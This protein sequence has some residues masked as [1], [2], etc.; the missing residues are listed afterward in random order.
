MHPVHQFLE[1]KQAAGDT[2]PGLPEACALATCGADG[3]PS[4]R[5][6]LLKGASESGFVFYT[7][8]GSRKAAQLS[9]NAK[10]ALCFHWKSKS[11]QIRIEG[12]CQPVSDEVADA[13]FGSRDRIARIGAWASKQSQPLESRLALEKQVAKR[14]AQFG[15]GEVPRPPFWSGFCLVPNRV[16]FWEELPFR[17]HRRSEWSSA[18]NGWTQRMLYP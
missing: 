11:R 17:L 5:M 18:E 8:L 4:V 7:N 3:Q 16:E 6:V 15:L 1:W 9:E 12:E 2:E 13:Y 14:T 10:A